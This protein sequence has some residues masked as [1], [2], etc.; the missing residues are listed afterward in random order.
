M[1]SRFF[2]TKKDHTPL[3]RSVG[4]VDLANEAD[5]PPIV[6]RVVVEIRSDGTRTIARGALEDLTTGEQ[7]RIQANA[8][9]PVALARELA[10]TLLLTPALATSLARQAMR[11][12]LPL[13]VPRDDAGKIT[14]PKTKLP[15][16]LKKR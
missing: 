12:L 14:W 2:S 1:D 9:S 4:D 16:P 10:R 8:H 15:W 6:A 13:A 11:E 3:S 7:V 5:L